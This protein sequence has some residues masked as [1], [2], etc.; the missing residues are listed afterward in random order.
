MKPN[1]RS[2]LIAVYAL[3]TMPLLADAA[4][5]PLKPLF[6]LDGPVKEGWV[7]RDWADISQAPEERI[8]WN[9]RDGVLQAGQLTNKWTGTWLMSGREYGDFI[10]ELDFKFKN[11]GRR[12]NGGIALRAPLK[13]DPAYDGFEMQITDPRYERSLFPDARP[14]QLTGALY[15]VHPPKK[16]MYRAGDWNHYRIEMRG[17]MVKAWL[18]GEQIQDLDVSTLTTPAKKHGEGQELLDA[19]PGA[20]RPRRGHIGFQDL[21]DHGEV[22]LFRNLKIAAID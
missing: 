5:T 8:S 7:V 15:L 11:G 6:P 3:F 2:K 16:Q 19:T 20:R 21:S 10:L 17:S 1:H 4:E 12:G 9:V 22:L 14:D 18:N 13:G